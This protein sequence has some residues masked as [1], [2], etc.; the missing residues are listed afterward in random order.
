MWPELL[1]RH[2]AKRETF[3]LRTGDSLSCTP[4]N[5]DSW[6]EE[7]RLLDL[8]ELELF[9]TCGSWRYHKA[10]FGETSACPVLLNLQFTESISMYPFVCG[11]GDRWPRKDEF[12]FVNY[13][14]QQRLCIK[15]ILH[16]LSV[17]LKNLWWHNTFILINI[18]FCQWL[19]TNIC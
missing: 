7:S 1:T 16:Q 18:L 17:I 10:S 14:C 11:K 5:V 2:T 9:H 13:Y 12:T 8:S 4:N 15:V 3:H 6:H 19:V